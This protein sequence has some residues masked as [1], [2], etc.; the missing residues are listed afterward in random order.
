MIDAHHQSTAQAYKRNG[1]LEPAAVGPKIHDADFGL[2]WA[3]WRLNDRLEANTL[4]KE[5]KMPFGYWNRVELG[6][7]RS[8]LNAFPSKGVKRFEQ[9]I[10][11]LMGQTLNQAIG[12]PIVQKDSLRDRRMPKVRQR[13]F[14][15]TEVPVGITCPFDIK[16]VAVVE[17]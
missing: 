15:D 7:R 11:A 8:E 4:L 1:R 12:E 17:G 2:C 13:K 5:I 3:M 14:A 10:L 16:V 6:V 9:K